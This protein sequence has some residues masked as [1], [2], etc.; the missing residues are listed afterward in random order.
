VHHLEELVVENGFGLFHEVLTLK[1]HQ[2]R[3]EAVCEDLVDVR[4][5]STE[6]EVLLI[7]LLVVDM[8]SQNGV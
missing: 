4:V 1:S 2:L 3:R 7:L 6:L 5:N 8:A